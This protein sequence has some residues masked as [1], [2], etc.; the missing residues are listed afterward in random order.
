M[1]GLNFAMLVAGLALCGCLNSSQAESP[2]VAFAGFDTTVTVGE[3]VVL[4]GSGSVDPLRKGL[5]FKWSLEY[6]P[7]GSKVALS[8]AYTPAPDFTPDKPGLYVFGLV[9]SDAHETSRRDLVSL[10]A[11]E[12]PK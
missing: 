10:T 9:V 3:K 8:G 11:T 2:P 5:E 12:N 7:E 4:D 6:V 1:K